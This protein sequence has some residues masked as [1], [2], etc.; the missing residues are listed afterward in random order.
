MAALLALSW[1]A[2][3]SRLQ[4]YATV[5]GESAAFG[6]R[7]EGRRPPPGAAGAGRGGGRA[8]QGLWRAPREG[9]PPPPGRGGHRERPTAP[10]GPAPRAPA[11]AGAPRPGP[12]PPPP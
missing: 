7:P 1:H 12:A 11:P 8:V 2:R 5:R 10:R 6:P 3:R 4:R 9:R